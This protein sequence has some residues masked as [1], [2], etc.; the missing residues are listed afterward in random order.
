MKQGLCSTGPWAGFLRYATASCLVLGTLA[1]CAC[2]VLAGWR[3]IAL[4]DCFGTQFDT[5]FLV[6]SNGDLWIAVFDAGAAAYD[7]V[8]CRHYGFVESG[9]TDVTA[10]LEDHAGTTWFATWDG[11]FS[12]DGERWINHGG[13]LVH[14][15]DFYLGRMCEDSSARLW[16]G[17]NGAGVYCY[18]GEAWSNYTTDDGLADDYVMA[19]CQD[20]HGNVWFGTSRWVSR[21][22]GSAWFAYTAADGLPGNYVMDIKEDSSGNLWFATNLGVTRFDG[23]AWTTFG[24][25]DGLPSGWTRTVFGDRSGRLWVGTGAGVCC[26][27]GAAWKVFT[28]RDGLLDD[29]VVQIGQD[30]LG[31]IC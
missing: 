20:R 14:S 10:M 29:N 27:D 30:P 9:E 17:T 8:H 2:P 18:D 28:T 31:N 5:D 11:L 24:V 23:T 12:Y 19:V 13:P 7:G 26:Y 21:Y 6:D 25:G 22:D 1:G 3:A 15:E 4:P 16:F